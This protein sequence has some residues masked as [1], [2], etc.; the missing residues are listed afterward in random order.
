MDTSEPGR[1]VERGTI[2]QSLVRGLRVITAFDA[3]NSAMTMSDI[4][5]RTGIPRAAVGR[6][7]RTLEDQ[8]YVR[9]SADGRYSLTP[10]VLELGYGY[11]SALTLPEVAQPHLETLSARVGE[12]ASASVLDDGDIVY[13]ARVPTH[14][15][16]GLRISIGTRF[17]AAVTSMGRV[18]LA[19]LDD[20]EL[21]RVLALHP[22]ENRTSRTIS[23]LDALYEQLA[24]VREKGYALVDE[25]LEVGLRSVAAPVR[26]GLSGPV[27]AAVNVSTSTARHS[28]SDIVSD[29][30]PALLHAADQIAL[31]LASIP[32]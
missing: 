31:E 23:S 21:R 22:L 4:A 26:R 16:M 28:V 2:V 10:R 17:P 8:G 32:G 27:V 7:L 6:F 5:R 15:I 30:L 13:V 1:D 19:A 11:L 3:A 20:D 9:P 24:S 29:L 14:R 25:E 12:S 18:M